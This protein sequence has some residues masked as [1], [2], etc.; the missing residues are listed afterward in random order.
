MELP[1]ELMP[2]ALKSGH[3]QVQVLECIRVLGQTFGELGTWDTYCTTVEMLGPD[4][5]YTRI[6]AKTVLTDETLRTQLEALHLELHTWL[7]R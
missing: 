4:C 3:T 1:D 5:P 2:P 6:A 7:M